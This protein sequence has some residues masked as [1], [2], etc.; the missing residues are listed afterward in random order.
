MRYFIGFLL[1]LGMAKA[2]VKLPTPVRVLPK[3]DG[4]GAGELVL[5]NAVASVICT[6]ANYAT[7]KPLILRQTGIDASN[8]A[9]DLNISMGTG[10][11]MIVCHGGLGGWEF[12]VATFSGRNGG[13]A[14]STEF[15]VNNTNGA[16]SSSTGIGFYESA[17]ISGDFVA[18]R[19]P[20]GAVTSS[21]TINLPGTG[22]SVA[23]QALSWV[24]GSTYAW[25]L[26]M[27][28]P[29]TTTGDVVYSSSGSTPAR[30]GIGTAGQCLVVT[31]GLPAW[32]SCASAASPFIDTTAILYSAATPANTLTESLAGL[33]AAR[34]WT[35]PDYNMVPAATNHT[36]TFSAD[37]TFASKILW[38]ANNTRDI[39]TSANRAANIWAY[40]I[41]ESPKYRIDLMS[42]TTVSSYFD[43]EMSGANILQLKDSG[44][45]TRL[46]MD[47]SLGTPMLSDYGSLDV[48]HA[49]YS[50]DMAGFGVR[51]V[52][53]GNTGLLSVAAAGC[54]AGTG[55]VT[56]VGQSFTGG[57]ISVAGSPVTTS[58]TLALTVA[59][60]SGGVPYFSSSSAWASSAAMTA[61]GVMIGGG[62]GTAPTSTSAGTSGQ[63]LMSNGSGSD[64]T[65]KS[66]VSILGKFTSNNTTGGTN[67]FEQSNGNFSV[68][69]NGFLNAVNLNGTASGTS[70]AIQ[71][72]LGSFL[73]DGNGKTTVSSL[74]T[75]GNISSSGGYINGTEVRV[76]SNV[77]I[78]SSGVL[79]NAFGV[80][81]NAGV[82]GTGFNIHG[83]ASGQT[84][85]V[86]VRDS[87]GTGTCTIIFT[88]GIKTGGTC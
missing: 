45:N 80:D 86:T 51:C 67:T 35:I 57:L 44:G 48:Q 16:I 82:A 61:H 70:T 24:S 68:G 47:A 69:V 79:S 12:N 85:T 87:A 64:P 25:T 27:T 33:T 17:G 34:T 46:Q 11:D 1:A 81:V 78:N 58:G 62:A 8:L 23:G 9:A 29:M 59:G 37:Q 56:S 72:N 32:G 66:D 54:A 77:V 5:G 30:L 20:A 13:C 40:T 74:V 3:A 75:A 21:Y 42:G 53:V 28:N 26:G 41:L 49:I 31:A 88:G 6:S 73:V 2:Q 76:A 7:C 84:A 14:G 4:S 65:F 50:G 71:N 63:A 10:R 39:G 83:G 55:T 19:A 18:M 43:W 22:P 38:D 60:T 36:Q 15:L 52:Q